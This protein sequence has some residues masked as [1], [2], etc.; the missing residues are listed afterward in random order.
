VRNVASSMAESPPPTTTRRLSRKKNPSQVAQADT[1]R[2]VSRDSPGTPSH[3]ADAPV[4]TITVW[5]RCS[6]APTSTPNGRLPK[7]TAV[8]VASDSRAPNRSACLRNWSI[9]SGPMIPSGKPG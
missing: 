3:F 6:S 2:P 7:S 4:A 5:A 8:D 1:P 9:S